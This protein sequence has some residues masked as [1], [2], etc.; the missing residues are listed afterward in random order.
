AGVP[1][2]GKAAVVATAM[3]CPYP[4]M[5][6]FHAEDARFFYGR[7]AEIRQLV[8]HLRQQHFLLVIGPSGSG[9][10][11]LISAGLLPQLA[12]SPYWAPGYWRVVTM[13]PGSQP[14][15]ALIGRLGSDQV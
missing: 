7:T 9:K 6:P 14:V 2:N 12:N 8:L 1:V 3:V 13:R 5:V 4:G 15:A 10:S 11:S